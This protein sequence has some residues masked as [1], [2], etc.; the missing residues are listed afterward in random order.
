MLGCKLNKQIHEKK[1][2]HFLND[3]IRGNRQMGQQARVFIALP[4]DLNLVFRTRVGL[5]AL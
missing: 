4:E 5:T 2:K 3:S 1:A